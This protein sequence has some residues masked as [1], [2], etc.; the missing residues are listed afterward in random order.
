LPN[1]LI[2]GAMK[3]GTSALHRY[4]AVH[5]EI[6]MA[7]PKELNFF[8]GPAELPVDPSAWS[9]HRGNWHRGIAWYRRQFADAPVRGE[10]SPA[11][12]SPSFPYAAARIGRLIPGARLVYM[13]RDPVARAVSQYLH[14]KADGTERRSLAEALLDPRSQYVARSRFYERLTPFLAH[15]APQRILICAHEDLVR[16]RR[17]QLRRIHRFVGVDDTFSSRAYDASVDL[18]SAPRIPRDLHARLVAH[19]A[20]DALRLR[21]FAGCD[22]QGWSL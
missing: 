14:H 7:T 18:R 4:L 13:V 8:V 12:T 21:E 6:A 9:W 1:L 11:Y 17:A 15:F 2:I 22:F 16:D 5:P 20:D 10:A 19:L 3:C